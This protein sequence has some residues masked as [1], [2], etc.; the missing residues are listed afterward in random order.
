MIC[1][2]CGNTVVSWEKLIIRKY[3]ETRYYH[4]QCWELIVI[5]ENN[6]LRKEKRSKND[7]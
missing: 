4:I 7:L 6:L 5:R 3:G 1:H 2:K